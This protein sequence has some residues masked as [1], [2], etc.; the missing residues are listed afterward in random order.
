MRLAIRRKVRQVHIV[1]TVGQESVS[2]RSEYSWFVAAEVIREN[3][4]KSRSSLRFIFIMPVRT[5]P[6]ATVLDLFHGETEQEHV[7]LA[8]LLRHFDGRAVP[9]SDGQGSVHHELHI[10]RSTGF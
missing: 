5:V 1:I 4:V 3:E 7:F 6:G 2:Q 8:C 9:R 10:A